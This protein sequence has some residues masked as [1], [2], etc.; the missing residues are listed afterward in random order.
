MAE[1]EVFNAYF[2]DLVT[3]VECCC[4]DITN[5]CLSK[6]LITTETHRS[7]LSTSGTGEKATKL[8]SAIKSCLNHQKDCF[9]KFV[10]ILKDQIIFDD[11]IASIEKSLLEAKERKVTAECTDKQPKGIKPSLLKLLPKI[12]APS[13]KTP[14]VV[15]HT[16]VDVMVV[17]EA[18]VKTHLPRISSAVRAKI[19]PVASASRSQQLISSDLYKQIIQSKKSKK[20]RTHLLLSN[21]CKCVRH[22]AE[23]FDA[24]LALLQDCCPA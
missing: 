3:S 9:H 1:L 12:V 4:L 7:I 10:G 8:M 20:D 14:L 24:F 2:S 19:A 13:T 15:A 5:N 21:V 11:L 23:K 22:H 6:K 16:E 18:V 17:R